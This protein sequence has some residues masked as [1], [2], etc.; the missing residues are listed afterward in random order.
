MNLHLTMPE[1]ID[2]D[3]TKVLIT[4]ND[5]ITS[6]TDFTADEWADIPAIHLYHTTD[7][8]ICRLGR[9]VLPRLVTGVSQADIGA[10]LFLA[11]QLYAPSCHG[12]TN[13]LFEEPCCVTIDDV[14]YFSL[15]AS[16]LRLFTKSPE[17]YVRAWNHI[18]NGYEKVYGL[19]C[20]IRNIT[21]AYRAVKAIHFQFSVN[22]M[23]KAT[24][25]RLLYA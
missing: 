17:N 21:P 14:L 12:R 22:D 11:F 9:L 19:P 20:P 23:C 2:I 7:L 6:K 3:L 15:S 13:K 16:T 5:L 1:A 8:E 4:L 10:L 25:H 18:V 24:L